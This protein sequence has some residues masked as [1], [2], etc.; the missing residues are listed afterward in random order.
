M[1]ALRELGG[2]NGRGGWLSAHKARAVRSGF[3]EDLALSRLYQE[4]FALL[5]TP[6]VDPVAA[7][8]AVGAYGRAVQDKLDGRAPAGGPA[9]RA[10]EEDR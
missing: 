1:T 7:A 8:G 3:A 4:A 10:E 9:G 5:T 6:P 2:G